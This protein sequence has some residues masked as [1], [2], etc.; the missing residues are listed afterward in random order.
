MGRGAAALAMASTVLLAACGSAK[1]GA[2]GA[3][4]LQAT[5]CQ[6]GLVCIPPPQSQGGASHCSSDTAQIQLVEDAAPPVDAAKRDSAA[7]DARA[8]QPDAMT[9]IDAGAPVDDA[10][11]TDDAAGE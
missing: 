7:G 9:P 8:P 11:P 1:L 10:A 4:C 6:E 5:D 2:A 3:T